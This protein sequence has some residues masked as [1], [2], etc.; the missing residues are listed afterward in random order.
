MFRQ[1]GETAR[2]GRVPGSMSLSLVPGSRSAVALP[3]S[4]TTLPRRWPGS[5]CSTMPLALGNLVEG[6][7]RHRNAATQPDGRSV[8]ALSGG[9]HCYPLPSLCSRTTKHTVS[10]FCIS[11]VPSNVVSKDVFGSPGQAEGRSTAVGDSA[12]NWQSLGQ[13][14]FPGSAAEDSA[15]TLLSGALF[16]AL[17]LSSKTGQ[18]SLWNPDSS[19]RAADLLAAGSQSTVS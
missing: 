19:S 14:V 9:S 8:A 18:Q 11:S 15:C 5:T 12:V 16:R 10:Y 17:L 3:T 13:Q 4:L 1:E 7:G 2:S 6:I